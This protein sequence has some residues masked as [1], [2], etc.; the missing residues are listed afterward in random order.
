MLA[1]SLNSSGILPFTQISFH[2]LNSLN[3]LPDSSKPE[4]RTEGTLQNLSL[5]GETLHTLATGT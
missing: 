5:K 3:M 4:G 2:A 1:P